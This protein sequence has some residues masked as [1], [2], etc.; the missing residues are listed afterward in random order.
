MHATGDKEIIRLVTDKNSKWHAH[1]S[2]YL[3]APSLEAEAY[4]YRT[5]FCERFHCQ[6]IQECKCLHAGKMSSFIIAAT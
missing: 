5:N 1:I 4:L 3:A 6:K 2:V